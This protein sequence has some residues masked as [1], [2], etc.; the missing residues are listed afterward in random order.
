M[1]KLYK[2]WLRLFRL[3]HAYGQLIALILVP[4]VIFS[5]VGAV[6]VYRETQ[7]NHFL[8]QGHLAYAFLSKYQQPLEQLEQRNIHDYEQV[9]QQRQI[10]QML[11]NE[12][13]VQAATLLSAKQSLSVGKNS[14]S[15]SVLSL[16]QHYTQQNEFIGPLVY[17]DNHVYAL[18]LKP[19]H[20]EPLWLVVELGN[21]SLA[22]AEY[23]IL[24]ILMM[25]GVL[26]FGFLLLGLLFFYRQWLSPLYKMRM[27]LQRMTSEKLGDYHMV[28]SA[29]ELTLLQR[30]TLNLLRRLND[31]FVELRHYA[32]QTQDDTRHML[33]RAEIQSEEYKALLTQAK[34][35]NQSKSLFLANIS[36]ELRTPLNS[37]S[38]FIHLLL[39]QSNMTSEQQLHLQ[40]IEKSSAHLLALI[41]DVLD[42]SKIEAGKLQ[43]NANE[44]DLEKAMFDVMD[45]LTPLAS[46]KALHLIFYYPPDVPQKVQGDDLRFKQIL[47]NL[48]SNAIKFTK[49]GE[50]I[51]RVR[52]EQYRQEQQQYVLH[53]SVQDSGT[54]IK[55]EDSGKLFKFFSQ[56]DASV[57]RQY[58]GTGLGLAISKQLVQLMGGHIGFEDNQQHMLTAKGTTFW[59]S[60]PLHAVDAPQ[61]SMTLPDI[62]VLSYL[63]HVETASSLRYYLQHLHCTHHEAISVFDLFDQL[64]HTPAHSHAWLIVDESADLEASLKQIRERYQGNLAIYGHQRSLN[65]ELLQRYHA[66][67]LYQPVN[68]QALIR[69]FTQQTAQHSS[70]PQQYDGQHLHILAVDDHLPNLMVLEALLQE[71]N[72][73]LIKA[74]SG[75]EAVHIIQQRIEQKQPLFDLIFMDIQMPKMSGMDT[76]RAIRTLEATLDNDVRMP[77]LALSAHLLTDEQPQ[78]RE[79][80]MDDDLLKPIPP[81]QILPILEKWIK[82]NF[83]ARVNADVVATNAVTAPAMPLDT[84]ILDWQMSLTLASNKADLAYDLLQ[85]LVQNFEQ[86]CFEI[87]DLIE[88][89][90]FPQLEFVLHRIYGATRYVGTPKLQQLTGEFEQFVRS[91]RQTQRLADDAFTEQAVQRF[92]DLKA[93]MQDVKKAVEQLPPPKR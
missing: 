46:E 41:N 89:E 7:Q 10:L 63:Q 77:I 83:I 84:Q 81:N 75:M 27:Q 56:A 64:G 57:T 36:H 49:E 33:D 35:I 28:K 20:G 47:T 32:E 31:D 80:G 65:L 51:V 58:G 85:M 2:K 6:V 87:Q 18:T 79:S 50:V 37:I 12:K 45:M 23:R 93:C 74:L 71:Y 90:D 66:Q 69:L 8:Q 5:A 59:F 73:K 16:V 61:E 42:Y 14:S 13:E 53:F 30:D 60:L 1:I 48:V 17:G 52:L 70:Q 21:Q 67:A 11:L 3:N 24:L 91:L 9:T 38:G 82:E 88:L 86:D 76:A 34:N 44:F 92:N 15:E 4:I 68:R 19:K 29:G 78:L 55:R 22:V 43:L 25:T 26:T 62:S 39:K 72:I 40:T 54:G